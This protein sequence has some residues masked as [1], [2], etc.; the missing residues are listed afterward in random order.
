MKD[1]SILRQFDQYIDELVTSGKADGLDIQTLK[2]YA[3]SNADDTPDAD[4]LT[5]ATGT[6]HMYCD[7]RDSCSED[8]F[9]KGGN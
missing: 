9:K 5:I 1:L 4:W 2:A 6:A 3:M 8:M 7:D